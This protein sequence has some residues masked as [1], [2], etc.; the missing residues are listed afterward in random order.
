MLKLSNNPNLIYT[1]DEKTC[2]NCNLILKQP[3]PVVPGQFTEQEVTFHCMPTDAT[4]H[5]SLLYDLIINDKLG[6]IQNK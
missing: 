5:G 6:P 2:V 3:N 4:L 1:D